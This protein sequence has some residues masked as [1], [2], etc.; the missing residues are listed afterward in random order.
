MIASFIVFDFP[1]TKNDFVYYL[2]STK[3]FINNKY[4][5]EI[6]HLIIINKIIIKKPDKYGLFY[7]PPVIILLII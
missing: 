2:Q 4:F 7:F 3:L 1:E 6:N 5:Y